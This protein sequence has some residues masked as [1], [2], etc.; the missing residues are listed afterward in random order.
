MT[1]LRTGLLTGGLLAGTLLLGTVG[2]VAA[3]DHFITPT[4]SPTAVAPGDMMGDQNGADM[5]GG[6]NGARMMGGQNGADMMGGQ[7]GAE[8]MGTMSADQL[9]Q[10]TTLHDQVVRTGVRDPAQMRGLHAQLK[11]AR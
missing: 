5:M 6:Q 4:P 10:M 11:P 9:K 7:N 1:S 2:S 8:M 3:Q